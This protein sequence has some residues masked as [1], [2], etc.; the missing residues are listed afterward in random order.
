MTATLLVRLLGLMTSLG[1]G[2]LVF[3]YSG[4]GAEAAHAVSGTV[5]VDGR[6]LAKGTIRFMPTAVTQSVGAAAEVVNGEY[7]VSEDLGLFPGRYQVCVSGIGLAES[8]QANREAGD[9]PAQLTDTDTVP[10]RFNQQSEIFV[11][12]TEDGNIL[13]FDFDLK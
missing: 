1:F 4:A 3:D 8:I 13:G 11:E 6:P 12:V 9:A 5:R 10:A 7:A 2:Y